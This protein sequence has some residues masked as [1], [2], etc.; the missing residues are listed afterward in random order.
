MYICEYEQ[1]K[2]HSPWRS[3]PYGKAGSCAV[4]HVAEYGGCFS[5]SP[6]WQGEFGA[7][8]FLWHGLWFRCLLSLES[9]RTSI[10][11]RQAMK[12]HLTEAERSRYAM[13]SAM[14]IEIERCHHMGG[15]GPWPCI[16]PSGHSGPC[17]DSGPYVRCAHDIG[18]C[19]LWGK[20]RL[21]H[22]WGTTSPWCI[23]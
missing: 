6:V 20:A 13:M 21:P 14:G 23:W 7:V 11:R 22:D 19:P 10:H 8:C 3:L 18:Q 4:R 16:L 17:V 2:T 1:N 5:A 9:A 15:V 12:C